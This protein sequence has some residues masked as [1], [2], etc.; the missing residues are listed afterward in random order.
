MRFI[1]FE[2]RRVAL[3]FYG[4]YVKI[5]FIKLNSSKN[6]VTNLTFNL[7]DMS[8]FQFVNVCQNATLAG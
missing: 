3:T 2:L 8:E 5:L 1:T 4:D 6:D 7:S